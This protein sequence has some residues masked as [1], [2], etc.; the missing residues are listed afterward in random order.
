M[1]L[2]RTRL[3]ACAIALGLASGASVSA[4]P[5]P[6]APAARDLA[7]QQG[8]ALTQRF[9]VTYRSDSR[10]QLAPAQVQQ[11]IA[12]A[13]AR[14][15]LRM[16]GADGRMQALQVRHLRRLATGA[17]VVRSAR[18]LDRNE[19]AALMRQIAADP[20]VAHVE[21]DALLRHA[22]I[23]AP[24]AV[25][26]LVP[27]DPEYL[28][29]QWHLHSLS[30]GIRAP[31]A[32]DR[33]N[34]SGTVVAVLDTGITA[35]PDLDANMLPGYD[36][37]S[38]ASVSRRG[39]DARAPGAQDR[40]DW[41][42][43]NDCYPG[44]PA[45]NSSW[46]GTHVAGTVAEATD[47]GMDLAGVAYGAKVLPLRVLGRCGGYTSD[48]ADAIVWAS[49]GSVTGLPANKQPAEVINLSLG[50]FGQCEATSALQRAIGKAVAA[51]TTVVV[52]AGN[53][54]APAQYF[55]PAS[56][57]RVISVGA[58]GFEGSVAG[59][60]NFG[61]AV[62]L[63]A[64]GGRGGIDGAI[65]G[66]VW[67]AW[68][69][70]PREPS[71]YASTFHGM[72]GTSMAAP[73][74]AGT[75]AVMQALAPVPLTPAKVESVLKT[76]ARKPSFLPPENQFRELI[77]LGSGIL[78]AGRAVARVACP[79]GGCLPSNIVPLQAGVPVPYLSASPGYEWTF[80]IRVTSTSPGLTLLSSGGTGDVSLLASFGSV[81]T[82]ADAQFRSIRPG[83]NELIRIATPRVGTYYVKVRG[84]A[85]VSSGITL[86]ARRQ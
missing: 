80:A 9:I 35:H 6:R 76:Y 2:P 71:P 43:A 17:D 10:Q 16:R 60:T 68:H 67:Q 4:P 55:T 44:S 28:D 20:M 57:A 63:A 22:G 27:D 74:V 47:N 79:A 5:A 39:S 83:N 53:D 64:P 62:D 61:D 70:A 25:A 12:A 46:H 21:A 24:A 82:L 42:L 58:T 18:A 86:Q 50:G 84:V 19:A 7:P 81:P 49:G 77:T 72:A 36:F 66:Y 85:Q 33:G 75:V 65:R 40:G 45:Q 30:G 15:G 1:L 69:G 52:A 29:K 38:D 73:H 59:Y 23:V 56:C 37:I 34:G 41:T 54:A 78:D 14:T 8:A 13:S 31:T 11:R 26:A 32:W 48:I 3:L 51:G